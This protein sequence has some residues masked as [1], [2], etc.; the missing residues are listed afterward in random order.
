MTGLAAAT[1]TPLQALAL[2]AGVPVLIAAVVTLAV[3]GVTA[4]RRRAD[5]GSTTVSRPVLGRPP[6]EPD[7]PGDDRDPPDRPGAPSP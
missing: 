5:R 1:I 3:Y 4:R 7:Q 6:D 2:F